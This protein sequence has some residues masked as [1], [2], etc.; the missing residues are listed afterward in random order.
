MAKQV[1]K[2]CITYSSQR[3]PDGVHP[4]ECICLPCFFKKNCCNTF[5]VYYSLILYLYG[6][7]TMRKLMSLSHG[8]FSTKVI[9]MIS[10]YFQHF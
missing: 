10:S 4:H 2:T 7:R 9:N 8:L 1:F 3:I 5:I 6:Y